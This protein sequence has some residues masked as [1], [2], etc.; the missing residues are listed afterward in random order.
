[1]YNND[2]KSQWQVGILFCYR[3]WVFFG[4]GTQIKKNRLSVYRCS[5]LSATCVTK[6]I[7]GDCTV[8]VVF[9]V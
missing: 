9:V 2:Y 4:E 8:F 3:I 6:F 7:Y 5:R 1:M